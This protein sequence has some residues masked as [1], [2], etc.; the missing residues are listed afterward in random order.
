MKRATGAALKS[1]ARVF[2]T[3]KRFGPVRMGARAARSL[4]GQSGIDLEA[5]AHGIRH[6]PSPRGRDP[7]PWPRSPPDTP[8]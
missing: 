4:K 1:S 7:P 6:K 2:Q 3:A 5:L 8:T